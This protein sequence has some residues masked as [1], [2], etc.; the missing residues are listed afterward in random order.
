MTEEERLGEARKAKDDEL[1]QKECNITL[2]ENRA[3]AIEI[4]AGQNIDT[5]L[6]DFVVDIDN[7][8]T[9]ENAALAA[10]TSFEDQIK[11]LMHRSHKRTIGL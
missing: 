11:P 6:V 5:K 7:G 1:A 9:A 8:K 4:L 3:D 2:R 10:N